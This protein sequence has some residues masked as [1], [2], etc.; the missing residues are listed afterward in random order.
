MAKPSAY[1]VGRDAVASRHA[2]NTAT[3]GVDEGYDPE[4]NCRHCVNLVYKDDLYRC[5]SG[6]LGKT[7][8]SAASLTSSPY[9]RDVAAACQNFSQRDRAIGKEG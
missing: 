3:E 2:R 7:Y 6:L 5:K 4:H 8:K 9:S 1:R